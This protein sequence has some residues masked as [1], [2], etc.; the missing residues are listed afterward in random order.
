[1]PVAISEG[2]G[3]ALAASVGCVDDNQTIY[4]EHAVVIRGVLD[5]NHST[6]YKRGDGE[7]DMIESRLLVA[8]RIGDGEVKRQRL[9]VR[10]VVQVPE[11][12]WAQAKSVLISPYRSFGVVEIEVRLSA[13]QKR[14]LYVDN[15]VPAVDAE[16]QEIVH[17]LAATLIV[18]TDFVGDLT[19]TRGGVEGF[20]SEA[21][22]LGSA[23]KVHVEADGDL[24]ADSTITVA[25]ALWADQETVAR[26]VKAL[27]AQE[28]HRTRDSHQVA[29]AI[30]LDDLK[31]REIS[32]RR[33]GSYQFV[34]D[35]VTNYGFNA[36]VGGRHGEGPT[37]VSFKD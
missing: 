15:L 31:L 10:S 26:D 37:Y 19:R 24:P 3:Q 22:W 32:I 17:E 16:L 12:S 28:Y 4:A 1:M 6:S 23:V 33:E 2:T 36:R 18:P 20:Q 25:A 29:A 30:S 13:C 11:E 7:L 5:P 27:L 21:Q 14:A 35:D 34:F 8:W 9:G